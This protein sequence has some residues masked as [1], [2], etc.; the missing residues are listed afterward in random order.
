[1]KAQQVKKNIGTS[2]G[3]FGSESMYAILAK[4]GDVGKGNSQVNVKC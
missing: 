3:K 1:M 4:D 2:Q